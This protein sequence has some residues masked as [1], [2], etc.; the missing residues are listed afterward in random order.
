MEGIVWTLGTLR[1]RA[2]EETWR[3]IQPLLGRIGCTRVAE[4]THLDP[5]GIPV[6]NA[7]RPLA[8]SLATALGKGVSSSL[9]RVSAAME[10]IESWYA[11]Q[12][13]EP[14]LVG[15]PRSKLSDSV[16]YPVTALDQ[17]RPT[18]LNDDFPLDWIPARTISSNRQTLVPRTY[19][20]LDRTVR[21][22][23]WHPPLFELT[24]NGLASGNSVDE[25]L[26]HG[27]CEII[28]REAIAES[29]LTLTTRPVDTDALDDPTVQG[30][31]ARIRRRSRGSV[32]LY[33][34][35]SALDVPCL[36]AITQ[37]DIL[38]VPFGG[39]GCHPEV[40]IAAARAITEAI[41]NRVALI[42]GSRDDLP[43]RMFRKA[44]SRSNPVDPPE[45]TAPVPP[46]VSLPLRSLRHA[47]EELCVRILARTGYEPV[48]VELSQPDDEVAVVRVVAPGLRNHTMHGLRIHGVRR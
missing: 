4:L 44:A 15:A 21:P 29:G 20:S 46:P 45:G 11:E 38:P 40:H 24:T 43:Y 25:A 2:P 22:G 3:I 12:P 13:R 30:L 47:V 28:E 1:T 18:L 41:Q 31:L 7:I 34:L 10:S 27:L 32:N 48:V 35:P 8:A 36:A 6:H 39:F 37:D 19:V 14:V 16:L 9:S 26:F 42:S 23:V 5:T 33:A 17:A